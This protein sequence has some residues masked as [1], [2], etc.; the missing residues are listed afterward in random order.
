MSSPLFT[1]ST[2]APFNY[3]GFSLHLLTSLVATPKFPSLFGPL[4]I[5]APSSF[6][7]LTVPNVPTAPI[8]ITLLNPVCEI[9]PPLDDHATCTPFVP[10]K[11][12]LGRYMQSRNF[13][14]PETSLLTFDYYSHH[15]RL[16]VPIRP[17]PVKVP[18]SPPPKLSQWTIT[19]VYYDMHRRRF[20]RSASQLL[21]SGK[22][23]GDSVMMTIKSK[24]SP[25]LIICN[26]CIEYIV[27]VPDLYP[28][29]FGLFT[30]GMLSFSFSLYS[31]LT[32]YS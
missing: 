9:I 13:V 18:K 15:P 25:A 14:S 1:P 6:P 2:M 17:K 11:N 16:P 31:Q 30:F 19:K 24:T 7:T 20:Q 28:R 10:V 21:D 32:F 26:S 27:R 8:N 22:K 3:T 12:N 23:R 5:G 4:Q 29:G